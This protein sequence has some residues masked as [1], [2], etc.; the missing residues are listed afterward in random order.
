[1]KTSKKDKIL[2]GLFFV[3]CFLF[4]AFMGY[5]FIA[6]GLKFS[7]KINEQTLLM[8]GYLLSGFI[9]LS[10]VVC[11]FAYFIIYQKVKSDNFSDEEGSAYEKYERK[12]SYVSILLSLIYPLFLASM[13]IYFNIDIFSK[14]NPMLASFLLIASSLSVFMSIYLQ[15]VQ[16]KILAKIDEKKDISILDFNFDKKYKASL[17]EL[18]NKIATEASYKTFKQMQSIMIAISMLF[19]VLDIN[20]A[21]SML[22]IALMISQILLYFYNALKIE[23]KLTQRK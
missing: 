14:Y 4:G 9:I 1:M 10:I 12:F 5:N 22:L 2:G 20:L 8:I 16:I 17:D 6:E 19:L 21:T 15:S 13:Y 23:K 3:F 11:S 7:F 18:E